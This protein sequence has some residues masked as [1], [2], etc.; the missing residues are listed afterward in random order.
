[1]RRRA[2]PAAGG[3]ASGTTPAAA[4]YVA[5]GLQWAS[6]FALPFATSSAPAKVPDVTVRLGRTRQRLPRHGGGRTPHAFDAAP[7]AALLR[8]AEVARYFITPTEIVVDPQGGNDDDIVAFLVGPALAAL[9][10]MR[11][12]ITLH[13]A[14]VEMNESAVLLLGTSGAGKSTLAFALGQR[15]HALLADDVTG[16]A[17]AAD[18]ALALPAFPAFRLWHDILR[19]EG[20]QVPVRQHLAQYWKPATRFAT[21]P[22]RVGAVFVLDSHN[23]NVLEFERLSPSRAFHAVWQHTYR[24]R[25]MDALGQ[26]RRHHE[27]GMALARQVP[28]VHVRRPE[29]PFRLRELADRIEAQ[30]CGDFAGG[31]LAATRPVCPARPATQTP[32]GW[33]SFQGGG[34]PGILWIAA[35]PKSGTTWT[36]VVLTNYLQDDD[37]PASINALIGS[38]GA[39]SRDKFDELIGID[40][41]DLRPDELEQYLPTFREF[42]ARSLSARPPGGGAGDHEC[43]PHFAKTHEAYRSAVGGARFSPKWTAG[44][45]YLVRNPLDVAVSYAHHLQLP[46]DQTIEWM[47]DPT[48]DEAPAAR[49]I[50]RLL[51]NPLTTWSSHV[52]SWLTQKDLRMCAVRYEDLLVEPRAW[53]GAIVRFAGLALDEA[54]LDRAIAHAAFPRLQA[55]E[56]ESG[57]RERQPTAPSF[58]RAG[59]AGSWRTALTCEQVAALVDAHGPVMRRLGYLGEAEAFLAGTGPKAPSRGHRPTDDGVRCR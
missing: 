5:Y 35:Y 15:G 58:F 26:R 47:N 50:R 34:P 49:N 28:F 37:E 42:L 59:V 40:S 54:R 7:G 13:A 39:S 44:V 27:I 11:G 17:A 22:R 33:R 12:V 30:V 52:S 3:S 10:Q 46:I 53:F 57:Y 38:W 56:A 36:R 23:Q 1:M 43:Q 21:V 8:V 29:W 48:A 51:P 16:L 4:Q 9:L 14:A 45:V 6:S 32:R 41:A 25:L 18:G 2:T 55:Q 20:R 24:K 31:K 19:A